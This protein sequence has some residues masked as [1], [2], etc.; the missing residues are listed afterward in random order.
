MNDD[1]AGEPIEFTPTELP[2][3]A[4]RP[5]QNQ[6]TVPVGQGRV[7]T[8]PSIG[9]LQPGSFSGRKEFQDRVFQTLQAAAMAGWREIIVCDAGFTDWPLGER[10]P[11]SLLQAWSRSG[12]KFTMIARNYD[13]LIRR[14]HR[15]V[16]WR[17]Q[18]AHIIDCRACPSAD[19]TEL[20]SVIWSPN[21]VL[22]RLDPVRSVGICSTEPARILGLK[23]ALDDW[24]SKSSPGFAATTLGL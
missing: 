12:R 5:A 13:E 1:A 17:R 3:S 22:Q 2:G 11:I 20:P 24:Y 7:T 4:V 15:F 23:E 10:L 19:A 9:E 14:H 21:W 8:D 18:W 6:V 16:S